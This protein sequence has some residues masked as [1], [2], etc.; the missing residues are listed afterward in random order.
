MRVEEILGPFRLEKT[1]L[2]D[3]DGKELAP[4][5]HIRCMNIPK[6]LELEFSDDFE[7]LEIKI[8]EASLNSEKLEKLIQLTFKGESKSMEIG[9]WLDAAKKIVEALKEVEL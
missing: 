2:T 3:T 6:D 9:I 7:E 8:A 1:K 4:W 5:V